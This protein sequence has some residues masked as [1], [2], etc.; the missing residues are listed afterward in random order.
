MNMP[1][2]TD[3]DIDR[4]Q[5]AAI[6]TGHRLSRNFARAI[7]AARDAQW[8]AKLAETSTPPAGERELP[9]LPEPFGYFCEWIA[10]VGFPPSQAMYYDGPGNGIDDDWNRHPEVHKNLPLFTEAQMLAFS[11]AVK[12]PIVVPASISAD[13]ANRLYGEDYGVDWVYDGAQQ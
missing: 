9:H 5:D 12:R 11:A 4:L 2:M 1:E 7:I 10:S 8:Q 6:G 13:D 3:A